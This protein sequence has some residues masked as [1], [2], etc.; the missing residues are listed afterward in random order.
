SD[1]VELR[2]LP[3]GVKKELDA[4][5]GCIAGTIPVDE[6][7]RLLI[8][9]GFEAPAIEVTGEQGVGGEQGATGSASIRAFKP[10]PDHGCEPL[11]QP[12]LPRSKPG[13]TDLREQIGGRVR[14]IVGRRRGPERAHSENHPMNS[15]SSGRAGE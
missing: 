4:W 15:S 3:A 2:P 13:S 9:A 12:S 6:Y 7:R 11:A 10:P 5:A 8:Q 14:Q 1:M